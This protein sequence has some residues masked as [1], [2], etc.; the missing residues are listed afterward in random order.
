MSKVGTLKTIFILIASIAF[1]T[2]AIAQP[3]F[4]GS[5]FKGNIPSQ[6]DTLFVRY[7][8]PFA[9]TGAD[10]KG[11]RVIS[12]ANGNFAFQ[13][14]Y[15]PHPFWM[16]INSKV[17]LFPTH[18][19]VESTDDITLVV[20]RNIKDPNK[21]TIIQGQGSEKYN[22]LQQMNALGS[23]FYVNTKQR[24]E[25]EKIDFSGTGDLE[26]KIKQ[27]NRLT[28]ALNEEKQRMLANSNIDSLMKKILDYEYG[29]IYGNWYWQMYDLCL[30]NKNN[31]ANLSIIERA[32]DEYEPKFSYPMEDHVSLC[33][34]FLRMI[35]IFEVQKLSIKSR[36]EGVGLRTLY[37][38]LQKK[39]TGKA[40]EL[41]VANS[42]LNGA[43]LSYTTY[44]DHEYDSLLIVS[45][46]QIFTSDSL[47]NRI[48]HRLNRATGA[49]FF[50]GSFYSQNGDLVKT[51]DLKGKVIL[52]DFW[53]VGCG[54]CI[55]FHR[56]FEKNIYP[57]IQNDTGFVYLSVGANPDKERW[58]QGLAS[59]LYTSQKYVNLTVGKLGLNHPFAKHYN[60]QSL[61]FA[62]VIDKKGKILSSSSFLSQVLE[63][64]NEEALQLL[65]KA[66][67]E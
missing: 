51:D 63:G 24:S 49:D 3:K 67:S 52:I 6:F 33:P 54:W 48:K 47:R 65:T 25:M 17:A 15:Y 32:F 9:L 13:L 29:M 22:L 4:K 57:R 50:N 28:S 55:N 11:F 44:T 64:K 7:L 2:A 18:Y 34:E 21:S 14:P 62:M 19:L 40:R 23:P 60:I 46:N 42:L 58:L 39:Y 12:D 61:P 36:G 37:D 10:Y 35:P 1:S 38:T 30:K 16:Q 66:L 8:E 41:I 45:N 5:I 26:F 20:D 59:G 56:A 27:L 43:G 31:P 53:S